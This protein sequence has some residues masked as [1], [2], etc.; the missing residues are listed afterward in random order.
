MSFSRYVTYICDEHNFIRKWI[1]PLLCLFAPDTANLQGYKFII[2]QYVIWPTWRRL[3]LVLNEPS[4]LLKFTLCAIGSAAEAACSFT[5]ASISPTS[6]YPG[7]AGCFVDEVF[8]FTISPLTVWT[9]AQQV[10]FTSPQNFV[11]VRDTDQRCFTVALYDWIG[12]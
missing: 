10:V 12:L 6:A 8:H 5:A 4:R 1:S 11:V 3:Q 7:T 2:L 9:L